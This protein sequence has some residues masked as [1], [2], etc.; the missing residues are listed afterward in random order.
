VYWLLRRHLVLGEQHRIIQ[1]GSALCF[2]LLPFWPLGGLSVAGIPLVLYAFLNIREG[3]YAWHHWLI[4]LLFPFYS[5]LVISGFFLL[6][7]LGL[8]WLWDLTRRRAATA[9][10]LALLLLSAGYLFTHYRLFLNFLVEEAFIS[11]RVEFAPYRYI[12]LKEALQR[13]WA[14]F[15]TG[16]IATR[17]LHR[18]LIFPFVLGAGLFVLQRAE[19]R[20]RTCFLVIAA[21][22]LVTLLW[23]GFLGSGKFNS[24]R[25]NRVI[26]QTSPSFRQG[27]PESRRRGW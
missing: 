20:T 6:L 22:I 17:S 5:L 27:V 15:H 7:S 1:A 14:L 8:L 3:A 13:T 16:L 12:D 11:H 9:T 4:L 21:Y 2:A 19:P 23:Y 10:L 26:A 18:F 25:G 24:D